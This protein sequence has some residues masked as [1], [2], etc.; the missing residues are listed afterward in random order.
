MNPASRDS[1][2][3]TL[4]GADSVS[5]ISHVRPDADTIGSALGLGL[6]LSGLGK[7]VHCAFS[8]SEALPGPLR[9]LPGVDLLVD[10]ERL[11]ASEVMVAV[12]AAT[13]GRLGDLESVFTAGTT[14]VCIDHHISN[15]GFADHDLVDPDSDCTAAIVLDVIDALDAELTP[16]IATCLYAGL[17]TDTGSFKWARPASF[18]VAA[19]LLEAGVDGARWSRLLLD[20]HPYSWLQMVSAVLADSVLDAEV[21]DGRGLVYAIV[22][23]DQMSGMNWDESESVIDIVRTAREAEVAAVF[24]EV[25]P[26]DWAVSLRSKTDVDLVPIAQSLGGGGH[27]RAAG[28]SDTGD[29]AGVVEHLLAALRA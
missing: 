19:R 29:A 17:V 8:G 12:D 18:G 5:I 1:V 14:T 28:Y 20:S 27:V 24:K 10:A 4:N 7:R 25:R 3:A 6:A 13:A 15:P 21:L 23:A 26:G 22:D 16:D 9:R 11:P 2:A